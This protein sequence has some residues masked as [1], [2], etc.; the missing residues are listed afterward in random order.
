MLG[1]TNSGGVLLLH[2]ARP[3]PESA[4]LVQLCCQRLF[5][6]KSRFTDEFHHALRDLAPSV[7][8]LPPARSAALCAGLTYSVM[9][10]ALVQDPPQVLEATL[11][12]VGADNHHQGFPDDAYGAFG[13]ALLRSV[14][15]VLAHGWSMEAS[16][17]WVAYYLWLNA[18]LC[19]GAAWAGASTAGR[20]PGGPS[21]SSG[22]RRRDPSLDDIFD[23]LR[24]TYFGDNP[25][26]LTSV[27]TRIM[28]RTGADLRAPRPDQRLDPAIVAMVVESLILMGFT[29]TSAAPGFTFIHQRLT[30]PI[31]P[32]ARRSWWRS[33]FGRPRRR[34]PN[35]SGQARR[36]A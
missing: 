17:A 4:R 9:W 24:A 22:H 14:R 2:V 18:H 15:V 27:C 20:P 16:S 1:A 6:A 34:A 7:R 11:H 28:L 13:H 21:W 36:R 25:R 26:G 35:P 30:P 8:S 33:L 31:D 5:A 19:H 23:D 3:A 32:P 29:P 10:A 12:R